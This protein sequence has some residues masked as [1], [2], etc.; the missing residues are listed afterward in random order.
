MMQPPRCPT[1][2]NENPPEYPPEEY[3][4][5]IECGAQ[6][7]SFR[8]PAAPDPYNRPQMDQYGRPQQGPP[9]F[10]PYGRPPG[11]YGGAQGGGYNNPQGGGGFGQPPGPAPRGGQDPYYGGQQGQPQ[12]NP[13]GNA[14]PPGPQGG[15][16]QQFG[17]GPAPSPYDGGQAP[18]HFG[19]PSS[20][21]LILESGVGKVEYPLDAKV[22]TIGRSRSNDISLEDARVS[23]HH[24]KIVRQDHGQGY[25]IEDLNSRNGTRVDERSVREATPLVE[26]SVIKI[27]DAVFRF[28]QGQP[29]QVGGQYGARPAPAPAQPQNP[30]GAPIPGPGVPAPQQAPVVYMS[31]WSPLQCPSCQGMNTMVQIVFGPAAQTAGA[32]AAARQ[33][34]IILGEGP[35]YPDGP[36]AE[37]RACGTRV[38]I[39][40]SGQ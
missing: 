21:R 34:Q 4:F 39:V 13:Y 33:G 8:P 15:G 17:Q 22:V 14:S 40:Q 38:R 5:C 10:D 24:A 9:P 2:G 37:C 27:G 3:P 11:P 23:R 35:G 12:G 29:A 25:A 1:C 6:L 16:F 26:G 20:A 32:Q 7:G 36:N 28:T 30:W 31:P 18:A 19:A